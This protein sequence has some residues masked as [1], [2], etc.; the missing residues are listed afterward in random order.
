MVHLEHREREHRR[1]AEGGDRLGDAVAVAFDLLVADVDAASASRA[2]MASTIE[3]TTV[4]TTVVP[5][6]HSIGT[7]HETSEAGCSNRR[8]TT[9]PKYASDATGTRIAYNHVLRSSKVMGT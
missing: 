7:A 1:G 6:A 3:P 4:P 8:G 9:T 2:A 5:T